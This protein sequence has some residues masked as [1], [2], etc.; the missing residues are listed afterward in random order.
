MTSRRALLL[1]TLAGPAA[2]AGARAELPAED[3]IRAILK[4]RVEIGR[5][6]TGIVAMVVDKTGQH[7]VTFGRPDTPD[8]RPLDGETVFEIGSITKV[9]TALLLTDMVT[10][11]EVAMADP[12]AKYVPASVKVPEFQGKPITLLDLATYTSGLPRWP[13]NLFIPDGPNPF[14]HYTMNQQYEALSAHVLRYEPGTHYEY[15]N[16]GFGLLGDVLARRA[17]LSYEDLLIERICWPLGLNSTRITLTPDMRTRMAQG[18]N[19]SLEPTS[20]WDLPAFEGAGAV[21]STANDLQIFLEACLGRRKTPLD[22]ALA[23]LLET[24]RPTGA[25]RIE[26]GLGWFISNFHGDPIVWKDG[27]TGGFATFIGF[28]PRWEQGAQVLTNSGNPRGNNDVGFHLIDDVYPL[29]KQRQ[30]LEA[31]PA[32]L[33]S[34]VG[35]YVLSPSFAITVRARGSRLFVQATNQSEFEAF[36]S[37]DTEFFLRVVDAQITFEP[38]GDGKGFM[39]ILHQNGRD[40]R[41]VRRD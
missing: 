39:L 17:G 33:A 38:A 11:G 7:L 24:R 13:D 12:V 20:L 8:E 31:D 15:A 27:G 34:Y 2:A 41:G 37:G 1:G 19:S 36:S 14:A 30:Q 6:S 40:R 25:R 35:T 21:R 18:H 9:L 23:M 28:S 32:V 5:Q 10:R 3:T 29:A 16:W 4:E 22:R 26:V